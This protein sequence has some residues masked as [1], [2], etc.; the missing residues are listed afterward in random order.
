MV[1]QQLVPSI[2]ADYKFQL[3]TTT[4]IPKLDCI[5]IPASVNAPG[6]GNSNIRPQPVKIDEK[7][8]NKY[9]YFVKFEPM[10]IQPRNYSYYYCG[11]QKFTSNDTAT[12]IN[13]PYGED[14]YNDNDY[15]NEEDKDRYRIKKIRELRKLKETESQKLRFRELIKLIKKYDKNKEESNRS[16]IKLANVLHEWITPK[17]NDHSVEI[18]MKQLLEV[19]IKETPTQKQKYLID[20][21]IKNI[22]KAS[23]LLLNEIGPNIEKRELKILLEE[24]FNELMNTQ[25]GVDNRI[26]SKNKSEKAITYNIQSWH[27][28]QKQLNHLLAIAKE[29][30]IKS[31]GIIS[32]DRP[33]I[34]RPSK[35]D[36]D[37][38]FYE[39]NKLIK[40]N[41][42]ISFKCSLKFTAE[43]WNIYFMKQHITEDSAK[44]I[45]KKTR[46]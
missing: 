16:Q 14:S 18:L 30:S 5:I 43:S 8:T 36:R 38:Q 29:V 19:Q 24:S 37:A 20:Q 40:E 11:Y 33:R 46:E 4:N 27:S 2:A 15:R 32:N 34:G 31:H 35:N 3:A 10:K 25:K 39:W 7:S 41:P 6:R 13:D 1:A 26:E 17:G 12:H 28:L 21:S 23:E 44:K 45:L 22:K 9:T 42:H